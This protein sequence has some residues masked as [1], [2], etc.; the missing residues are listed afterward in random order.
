VPS[1]ISLAAVSAVIFMAGAAREP[2]ANAA[3]DDACSLL[4]QA[5]VSA[6]VSVSVGAGQHQGTYKKTC[7]WYTTSNAA[8]GAKYVTLMLQGLD[9]FQAGKLA[10]VKTIVVTPASGIGD[11]AYYLA[12][13][14]NVGLI[15]KKGNAAFKVAVYGQLPLEKKQ[16]IEKTLALQ[17][18]SSL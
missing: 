7:T 5:Q 16:A 6:A 11:D 9:A 2:S 14:P 12:V 13:G 18:I 1:K 3:P 10:L 8:E 17:I 4:T 15:V